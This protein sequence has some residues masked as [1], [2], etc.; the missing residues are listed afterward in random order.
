MKDHYTKTVKASFTRWLMCLALITGIWTTNANAQV[1]VTVDVPTNTTPNLSGS[2]ASLQSALNALNGV[3]AMSGPIVLTCAPGS[4]TA[5]ATGFTVGSGSLNT[6]LNAAVSNMITI[7]TSGAVT[8]NAGV[9]TA[10]PTSVAPDGIIK[11]LGADWVTIDGLTFTDGNAANP[12]T[13][14]YGIGLFKFSAAD[15]SRNNTIKNCTINMQRINNASSTAP[16][17]EGAV[18]ILVINST[19]TTATTSLTPSVAA[20]SNSNNKL[21]T[22]T[23]N[24]GNYGIGLSGFAASSGVGPAP[25]ASTFLGDLS[26]DIGGTSALTGNTILNFGGGAATN[27]AAGIRANNQWS[28]NIQYNTVNN[29]NGS[30]VNHGTTLRGIFGQAGTSASA[31]ISNNIVTVKSAATTSA[32]TAI[33][34]AIGSTAASNTV[35]IASNTVQNCTYS[36]A[37]TGTFTGILNSASATTLSVSGNQIIN[38]AVGTAATASAPIFQGIYSSGSPTNWTVSNNTVSGNTINNNSGT[39]Y[40]YRAS[41]ST[42]T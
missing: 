28:I 5:P 33:E 32:L 37:T 36:T 23:I 9:G 6:V 42:L 18:G 19:P 12:A 40:C 10:T 35:T 4:E 34:N 17:F 38:N 24:G 26:N 39:M 14:E 25:T 11:L 20:G 8:I 21:Y 7:N 29:N 16:M 13:M 2:Y 27:P 15:G 1:T 31:T 3:T 30:G 41:T 22:N